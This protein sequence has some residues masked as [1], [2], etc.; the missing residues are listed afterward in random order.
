MSATPHPRVLIAGSLVLGAILGVMATLGVQG[1]FAWHRESGGRNDAV[2]R[3]R[4]DRIFDLSEGAPVKFAGM[5]AGRVLS[6]RPTGE[7]GAD[8]IEVRVTLP[9]LDGFRICA[10]D[11]ISIAWDALL[12]SAHVEITPGRDR[13]RFASEDEVLYGVHQKTLDELAASIER[14]GDAQ[15]DSR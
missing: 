15:T 14:R 9:E 10:S 5:K 13:S 3:V 4:F 1:F 2:Y 12:S 8:A 7:G 11:T 6:I